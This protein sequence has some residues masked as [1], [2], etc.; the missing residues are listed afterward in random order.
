M[1]IAILTLIAIYGVG[2]GKGE[3]DLFDLGLP[4]QFLHGVSNTLASWRGL[5]PENYPAS[6]EVTIGLVPYLILNFLAMWGICMLCHGELVRQ[7]PDP[8]HLTA[9]YLLIS[10]GGALGAMAVTLIAPHV[11]KTFYEWELSTFIGY[12]LCIGVLLWTVG[13]WA[14]TLDRQTPLRSKL[15]WLWLVPLAAVAVVGWVD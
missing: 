14:F 15:R 9:Y 13:R 4:G 7:R 5:P 10:A 6:P 11:F 12:L 8:K 1:P 2:V 3:T